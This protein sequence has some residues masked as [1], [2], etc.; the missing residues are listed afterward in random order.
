[1]YFD[2]FPLE[3]TLEA[4]GFAAS[5]STSV[6]VDSVTLELPAGAS[7]SDE[8][9]VPPGG[10]LVT[11]GE[12][13]LDASEAHGDPSK[14]FVSGLQDF[15]RT[16]VGALTRVPIV[17]TVVKLL[18]VAAR[19]SVAGGSVRSLLLLL[20]LLLSA[21]AHACSLLVQLKRK[22]DEST[23]ETGPSKRARV[24]GLRS[25][26]DLTVKHVH[27]RLLLEKARPV[28]AAMAVT[29]TGTLQWKALRATACRLLNET[30]VLRLGLPLPRLL[31]G[32]KPANN[33]GPAFGRCTLPL[34]CWPRSPRCC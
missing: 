10:R 6:W 34:S 15:A 12:R 17:Q 13:F 28:S 4:I 30:S 20:L 19:S 22:R 7:P 29:P 16:A 18:A 3:K 26:F 8:W 14:F 23:D 5:K 27:G 11:F 1:V 31:P 21:G 9:G 2:P 32:P 25:L 33:A 24:R